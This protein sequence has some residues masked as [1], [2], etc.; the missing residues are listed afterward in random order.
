[1]IK[2]EVMDDMVGKDDNQE[3]FCSQRESSG[4]KTL[5]EETGSQTA[6]GK[7]VKTISVTDKTGLCRCRDVTEKEDLM[8]TCKS[9]VTIRTGYQISGRKGNPGC[10]VDRLMGVINRRAHQLV[11][12]ENEI[13]EL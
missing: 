5:A 8:I 3:Q 12:F 6:V 1:M 10:K 7:E 9:G 11:K 2:M 4:K 13:P